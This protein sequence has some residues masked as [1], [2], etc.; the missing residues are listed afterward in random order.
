M[1]M[2][3]VE[4]GKK[5][6]TVQIE[7]ANGGSPRVTNGGLD[8]N[9]QDQFTPLINLYFAQAKGAPTTLTANVAI[10]DTTFVVADATDYVIGDYIGVFSGVSGEGR[11]YFADVLGVSGTTITVDTPFDFAFQSGDPT[12]ST[13]KDLSVNGSVTPQIFGVPGTGDYDIDITRLIFTM[14]LSSVGD[15]G[16]FGNITAL[17]NGL[18]LRTKDGV[19]RNIFNVKDNGELAGVSYD[20]TYTIRSTG[21]GTYGLRCRYTF[22]GQSKQGVTVRLKEGEELQFIVQDDLTGI[23][24]FH[25]LAEGHVVE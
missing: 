14:N 1:E 24:R 21:G 13:T 17:T 4:S 18:V 20:M 15:D 22:A 25:V 5:I 2:Q 6:Q 19:Y 16:K 7:G 10:G 12:I 11:Y 3:S 9:I 23:T 8:I